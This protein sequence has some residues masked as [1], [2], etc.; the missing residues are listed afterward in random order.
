M[1]D[2]Y[3]MGVRKYGYVDQLHTPCQIFYAARAQTI[4]QFPQVCPIFQRK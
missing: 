3:L 2:K 4:S 1:I